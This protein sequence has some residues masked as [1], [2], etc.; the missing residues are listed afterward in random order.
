MAQWLT[1]Q[2]SSIRRRSDPWPCSVGRGSSVAMSC[3]VGCRCNL[4]PV[5]LWLWCRP[6][7]AALIQ[8]LAWEPPD[9]TCAALKKKKKKKK[10]KEKKI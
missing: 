6:A 5:L 8:P 3:G 4:D 10:K 1:N 9:A 7:V 2:T